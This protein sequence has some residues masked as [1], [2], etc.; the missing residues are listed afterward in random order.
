M[1]RLAGCLG[2]GLDSNASC[3]IQLDISPPRR[4]QTLREV[5]QRITFEAACG[6]CR[7]L[8]QVLRDFE[9]AL[10]PPS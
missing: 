2:T 4:P 5:L 3:P 10:R 7:L 1:E 6:H 9:E 8:E